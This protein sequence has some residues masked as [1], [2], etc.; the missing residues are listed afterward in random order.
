VPRWSTGPVGKMHRAIVCDGTVVA[1]AESMEHAAHIVRVLNSSECGTA[2]R[3]VAELWDA[4]YALCDQWR[5]HQLAVD[6]MST[7]VRF[8]P[9]LPTSKVDKFGELG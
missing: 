8:T 2:G 1:V 6:I 9:A 4:V 3:E 5:P 7:L